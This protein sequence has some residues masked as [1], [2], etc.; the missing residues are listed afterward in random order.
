MHLHHV[1]PIIL[2]LHQKALENIETEQILVIRV[3]SK[4]FCALLENY[5][6]EGFDFVGVVIFVT[7][8]RAVKEFD[9]VL[10]GTGGCDAGTGG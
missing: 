10:E 7:G 6:V 5:G 1:I 3:T 2:L 4:G 8:Y 9:H